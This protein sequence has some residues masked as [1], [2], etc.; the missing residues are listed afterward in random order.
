VSRASDQGTRAIDK[1]KLITGA[2]TALPLGAAESGAPA[3]NACRRK[4]ERSSQPGAKPQVRTRIDQR[5]A[6]WQMRLQRPG[7]H[8]REVR[9]A[10]EQRP[11]RNG[12]LAQGL[13]RGRATDILPRDFDGGAPLVPALAY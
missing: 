2:Q 12:H 6:Q 11:E 1:S 7:Q 4:R 9:D 5:S 8:H 3:A 10:A 13:R